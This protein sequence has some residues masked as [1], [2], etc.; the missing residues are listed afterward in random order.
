MAAWGL[1]IFGIIFLIIGIVLVA[2]AIVWRVR[3]TTP[4]WTG[5][6]IATL[7]A[8]IISII[9]GLILLGLS[10]FYWTP[11]VVV[12]PPVAP[13]VVQSMTAR[14]QAFRQRMEYYEQQAA[15]EAAGEASRE[16][17]FQRPIIDPDTGTLTTVVGLQRKCNGMTV[18]Q[19]QNL[20]DQYDDY[21]YIC[22]D[23]LK[24]KR[25]EAGL[26]F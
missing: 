8:G 16:A 1:L 19:L 13:V 15:V 11:A 24:Y 26:P 14:Q 5:G 7:V 3:N 22:A 18:N 17:Y 9:L 20:A 4:V 25:A 2:L 21:R 12:T 10:Y 23:I 6:M